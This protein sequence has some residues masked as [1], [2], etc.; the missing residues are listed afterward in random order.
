MTFAETTTLPQQGFRAVSA[1]D[2]RPLSDAVF[3]I[4]TR[5]DTDTGQHVFMW[6]DIQRVFSN[7]KY[8]LDGT[9]VVPFM[10]NQCYEDL[11]PLRVQYRPGV[12]LDIVVGASEHTN[13]TSKT[14]LL[15]G[16]VFTRTL[17]AE[18]VTSPIS[19]QVEEL[20]ISDKAPEENRLIALSS[21]MDAGA[22]SSFHEYSRIYNS[23]FQAIALGQK[24]QAEIMA[25][26]ARN[27]Q[28]AMTVHFSHQKIESERNLALQQ[29]VI[30]MQKQMEQA[31]QRNKEELLLMQQKLDE[32]QQKMMQLQKQALDRLAIVQ[33]RVQALITQTYE[34]HE[35]PIPRLFIVLPKP[36][37]RLNILAKPFAKQFRLF[38]LCECGD[39]TKT[40]GSSIPH[41]IH[42]AKHEGYDIS[43]PTEFFEKYGSYVLTLLQILK[44]GVLAAGIV[45]PPLAQLDISEWLDIVK[46]VIGTSGHSIEALVDESISY[47]QN[48]QDIDETLDIFEDETIFEKAKVLEGA[49][50]RQLQSF[51]Q[52]YDKGRTL[53]NLYR[54]VTPEGHVKWVC[55]DHYRENYRESAV[56][57]FK[58]VVA[59]NRG[60][61][62]E[63]HGSIKLCLE[64]PIQARQFY[65][66]MIQARGIQELSIQFGWDATM[67]ELR[68]FTT[69]A[70]TS[71]I[72]CVSVDGK[73]LKRP[74]LDVVNRNRRFNPLVQLISNGSIQSMKLE[75]IEGLFSRVNIPTFTEAPRLRNLDLIGIDFTTPSAV[76]RLKSLLTCC[77]NLVELTLGTFEIGTTPKN[78]LDDNLPLFQTLKSLEIRYGS[79]TLR[80][81]YS[82][83]IIL[84]TTL[85]FYRPMRICNDYSANLER[86]RPTDPIPSEEKPEGFQ[87]YLLN[88][89]SDNPKITTILLSNVYDYH[90]VTEMIVTARERMISLKGSCA[91]ESL[92]IMYHTGS[93]N[94]I[95]LDVKCLDISDSQSLEVNT[96]FT[97]FTTVPWLGYDVEAMLC[98]LKHLGPFAKNLFFTSSCTFNDDMAL[99]L[100]E[101]TEANGSKLS[102][103]D[104]DCRSLT[105]VG[106]ECM[107]RVIQRSRCLFN[108]NMRYWGFTLAIDKPIGTSS[109]GCLEIDS[110]LRPNG[111]RGVCSVEA[112]LHV[113][114]HQGSVI[115]NL[116]LRFKFDNEMALTL[117]KS[118]RIDG[119]MISIL[120]I[121]CAFLTATGLECLDY[122]IQRSPNLVDI[123]LNNV[124]NTMDMEQRRWISSEWIGK[125]STS[126]TAKWLSRRWDVPRLQKL[127]IHTRGDLT[128]EFSQWLINMLSIPGPI[129][130]DLTAAEQPTPGSLEC[131]FES[132]KEIRLNCWNVSLR[133]WEAIV[134]AVDF[135]GLETLLI[136]GDH[137]NVKISTCLVDCLLQN[138]GANLP[139]KKL[140]LYSDKLVKSVHLEEMQRTR[141][142]L[143]KKYPKLE[144][145]IR[146]WMT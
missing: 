54:I 35:Y 50:L 15:H 65:E 16:D 97:L 60:D 80:N 44:Y 76:S 49:D 100:D 1:S 66:A 119:S 81:K 59:A 4:Q 31:M 141:A 42:L 90:R 29:E 143:E 7:A 124:Y 96:D 6:K 74:A 17:S 140:Y 61:Y 25:Q 39:H 8:L 46:D 112:I 91:L 36:T 105:L 30:R 89:I 84:E 27:I 130:P 113:L 135:S 101:S 86:G 115:K 137:L 127:D 28:D 56:Q 146:I 63:Q 9:L 67:D 111:H 18:A 87:L 132:L 125:D 10:T 102:I 58:E 40:P 106:L 138:S 47:I 117:E 22:R 110:A 21:D 103:L 139:L 85:E 128:P 107:D 73:S 88:I 2:L 24:H 83:G 62:D 92:T 33:N 121:D 45:L 77:R 68:D 116:D 26:E 12:V 64:S 52:I 37:E 114:K 108:S 145:S 95:L 129:A 144:F 104:V 122:I 98:F 19:K 123:K 70:I 13:F 142:M 134:K 53:G 5:I 38:F 43:Q 133:E 78:L 75:G 126:R 41:H 55:F 23:Y 131:A 93:K 69:A 3:Y 34:L 82:E 32:N 109:P 14:T 20:S 48:K 94:F 57:R 72:V 11:D 120:K 99:A 71:N 51:L 136:M 79:G 118:I